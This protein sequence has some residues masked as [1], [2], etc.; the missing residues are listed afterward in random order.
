[1]TQHSDTAK[2]RYKSGSRYSPDAMEKKRRRNCERWVEKSIKKYGSIFN[3]DQAIKEYKTQKNPKVSIFCNEHTHEFLVSPDN[4]VQL[5]YGG[6][7]YCEAEA[8]T[9]ASLKK[10]KEKFFVWFDENR[11]NNLE[12]VSEFFGM[13]QPLLFK[14]KIHTQQ[15]PEKFLPTRMM[16][17][18]GYGWG[19]S[20]CAQ[21]AA[22][23]RNRLNLEQLREEIERNLPA[24]ITIHKI[25]FD[26]I[27]AATRITLDCE[28]HGIQKPIGKAQ[29]ISSREKCATCSRERLGYADAKLRNLIESG[30]KGY[31]C[32]LGVMEIEAFGIRALKV[33]VT[34]R[35]L[36]QRYRESLIKIFY[37]VRPFEIDAYVLENRIKIKFYED[38][39]ERILKKGMGL[40]ERWTGDTEL[41]YFKSREPIIKY[42][43]QFIAELSDSKI[44]YRA[45]LD[46][47]I[48]PTPF[49]RKSEFEAGEFQGPVPVIGIDPETNE[50]LYRCSS[51]AEAHAMGFSNISMV[52][53]ENY[54]RTQSKG[55]RWFKAD[56]FD[57]NNIPPIEIPNAKAVYCV[58]R[59]QHF[60][61]TV[62]A[63]EKMRELGFAV[64]SSKISAVLNGRRPT[65][66]GFRWKS[67]NLSTS[68]IL[69][70][71]P[72]LFIE[73]A[74][75]PNSNA[76]KKV[77]LISVA[78]KTEK[79][80]ES[81]AD[82]AKFIGSTSSN[83]SRAIKKNGSVKGF[84]V[85]LA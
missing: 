75:A 51:I 10:E 63:E 45:E 42:V 27:V 60:R 78:D 56:D 38:K 3:Y 47:F 7:K 22:R 69:D 19:C 17:G 49:P 15:E 41:Y 34:T 57:A 25:E 74:P 35:T 21:E 44:D 55:V 58:E 68:E 62:E 29:F 24:G 50:I 4:H 1:M 20:V 80:F 81:K 12:I 8:V 85:K 6:C 52:I 46:S 73:Y 84:K 48:I 30:E 76:P 9:T 14:C 59:N 39:D 70:Q 37:E 5:K 53:S 82:A 32:S 26:E 36:E 13:T 66:G 23:E 83:I 33:G 79:I 11:A 40:G 16:H 64:N 54:G 65:A 2:R 77:I 67:S 43:K 31:P 18:P 72:E 61:S 71:N 28:T